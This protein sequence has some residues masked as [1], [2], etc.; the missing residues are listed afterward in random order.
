MTFRSWLAL[1]SSSLFSLALAAP[2]W[3]QPGPGRAPLP[4][5]ANDETDVAPVEPPKL[6]DIDDPMLKPLGSAKHVLRSWQEA[7]RLAKIQNSELTIAKENVELADGQIRES[8][9]RALPTLTG[10]GTVTHHLLHGDGFYFSSTGITQGQIP[11]PDT[12]WSASLQFRQPVFAPQA[13]YDYG[14]AKRAKSVK[15][16]SYSDR[17]RLVMAQVADAIVSVVTAERLA[18]VSRVALKSSL[19][20]LDLNQRRAR[21]GAASTVDVLRAEQSVTATRSQ[22]VSADEQVRRARENLGLA[23]GSAEPYGVVPGIRVDSLASDAKSVCHPVTNVDTRAD[24]RAATAEVE[25]AERNVK[26]TDWSFVPTVDFL[27]TATYNSNE[28]ATANSKHVTWTIGGLLTWNLYDGGLRYGTRA[29]NEANR[30]IASENLT[31]AKRQARVEALQAQR[32]V[33][34]ARANLAVAEKTRQLA[35]ESS[36]LARIAFESG[37]G[38]S[39]DL[40]DADQRLRSADLDLAVKEFELVRA[41]IAALLTLSN[42]E[43]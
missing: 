6:P 29:V 39:F 21:L 24:V 28:R 5:P 12:F 11:N 3:S 22:I 17:Q 15:R 8:L 43:V 7:V 36:R 10:T 16:L 9:S 34:V 1:V 33:D 23:L 25:V 18:E 20:T 31:Q 4:P 14:T 37:R 13:W 30:R 35:V 26:S 38:N 19:G 32:A 42:C 41:E 2:A 27:S 40:I